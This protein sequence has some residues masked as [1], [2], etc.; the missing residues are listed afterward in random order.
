MQNP[1][2]ILIGTGIMS[3]TLGIILKELN[4]EIIINIYERLDKPALE[5]SDAWNN[6]GTGHS[7]FCELNYTPEINGKIDVQKA[8]KIAESFEQTRQFWSYLVEKKIIEN[9]ESFIHS[10]PHLSF[11]WGSE[12]VAFLKKRFEALSKNPLFNDMTFSEDFNKLSQIMPLVFEGRNQT[13]KVAATFMKYGTDINFGSLTNSLLEYLSTQNG[14]N[15]YYNHEV[16]KLKQNEAGQWK[17]KIDRKSV[18]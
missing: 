18:V 5:S 6:A 12:N 15:I 7:A 4:P 9:P 16:K 8:I 2:V 14:V 1:D 3:A 10:V 11:V 13:E 17:L